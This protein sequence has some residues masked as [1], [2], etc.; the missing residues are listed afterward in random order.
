MSMLSDMAGGLLGGG[1]GSSKGI[2]ATSGADTTANFGSTTY[3]MPSA[4]SMAPT[5]PASGY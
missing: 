1:S 5:V 3:V 2:Q 4:A